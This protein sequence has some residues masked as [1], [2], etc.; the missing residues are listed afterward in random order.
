MTDDDVWQAPVLGEDGQ[1]L[2]QDMPPLTITGALTDYAN[3]PQPPTS[4]LGLLMDDQQM[5]DAGVN[6]DLSGTAPDVSV[7][8]ATGG[9]DQKVDPADGVAKVAGLTRQAI[10]DAHNAA[11]WLGQAPTLLKGVGAGVSQFMGS[12]GVASAKAAWQTV[13]GAA[14]EAA[15]HPVVAGL[16]TLTR[17]VSPPLYAVESL[18]RGANDLQSGAPDW[19]AVTGAIIRGMAVTGTSVVSPTLA[20]VANK[21]LPPDRVMGRAYN[22]SFADTDGR[23]LLLP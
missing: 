21:Y 12:P 15:S 19:D 2:E 3:Q 6:P 10:T 8:D 1:V 22:K 13:R 11:S 16:N 4:S 5:R 14:A 9:P 7:I 20:G 23:A 17:A 18:A